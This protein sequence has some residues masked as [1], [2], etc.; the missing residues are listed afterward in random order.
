MSAR[1]YRQIPEW[2]NLVSHLW[3]EFIEVRQRRV[4]V[5]D[6]GPVAFL[7]ADPPRPLL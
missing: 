5:D 2:P 3:H 1:R 4:D 6:L 7:D